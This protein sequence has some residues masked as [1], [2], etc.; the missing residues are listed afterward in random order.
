MTIV[1]RGGTYDV[2]KDRENLL[3]SP[4]K[5][6]GFTLDDVIKEPL[7]YVSNTL[8]FKAYP[9]FNNYLNGKNMFVEQGIGLKE[10]NALFRY[11]CSFNQLEL[12]PLLEGKNISANR[13]VFP[14][15]HGVEKMDFLVEVW[16]STEKEVFLDFGHYLVYWLGEKDTEIVDWVE[17]KTVEEITCF[18][19]K[20]LRKDGEEAANYKYKAIVCKDVSDAK[21]AIEGLEEWQKGL[22]KKQVKKIHKAYL[23]LVKNIVDDGQPQHVIYLKTPEQ[24][25]IFYFKWKDIKNLNRVLDTY[26]KK[27]QYGKEEEIP[28]EAKRIHEIERDCRSKV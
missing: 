7:K 10:R 19:K 23:I 11:F 18:P 14:F 9:L 17:T 2:E 6:Q 21:E 5:N 20:K 15:F 8:P 26:K 4:F 12:H 28:D 1:N 25:L 16:D 24:L 22:D 3:L 27:N 13:E